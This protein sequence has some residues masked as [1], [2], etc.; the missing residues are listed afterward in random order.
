MSTQTTTTPRA[1]RTMEE[2]ISIVL[3][4]GVTIAGAVILLG[5]ILSFIP[6]LDKGSGVDIDEL[7]D[8]GGT[9]VDVTPRTILDGIADFDP[10]AI[11]QVGL[12]ILLLTPIVRVAMTLWLFMR[13]SD[14]IFIG[15]TAVVL[16]VLLLGF[17]GIV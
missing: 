5:V 11:I 2:S 3:R 13:D 1:A 4:V 12:L 14:T 8:T 16:V 9:T 6:A 7:L 10:I 17:A 15:I